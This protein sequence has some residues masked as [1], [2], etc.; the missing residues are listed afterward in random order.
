V[1]RA[2][3]ATDQARG[4]AVPL[5]DSIGHH[6]ALQSTRRQT[7]RPPLSLAFI[8]GW[9]RIDRNAIFICGRTQT[10]RN[11]RCADKR[12]AKRSVAK[13]VISSR[14]WTWTW[15]WATDWTPPTN[16]WP[17]GDTNHG[18]W[19]R[20]SP[21]LCAGRRLITNQPVATQPSRTDSQTAW[22]VYMG[23]L[24]WACVNICQLPA[25]IIG[26]RIYYERPLPNSHG[27]LEYS[28]NVK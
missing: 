14:R 7:K 5:A 17:T 1:S 22:V 4:L 13:T 26:R 9:P 10:L 20:L 25:L 6:C 28:E 11:E 15:Y 23:G 8:G 18:G 16:N 2:G 19:T 12:D 27:S 21:R 3:R 24:L